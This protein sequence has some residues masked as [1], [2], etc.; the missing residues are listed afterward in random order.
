[1]RFNLPSRR[2]SCWI[3][4]YLQL[5]IAGPLFAIVPPQ[6]GENAGQRVEASGAITPTNATQPS[7]ILMLENNTARIGIDTTK[8]GAI[9][10]LSWKD[11]PGNIVN[12]HDP[13]RLIQQSYYAGRRLVRLADGQSKN[14]SPWS[15]NPIQGGGVGAWAHTTTA[16]LENNVLYS[17]ST[18]KLWDMDDEEA[19]AVMRQWTQ[20]EPNMPNVIAITCE[21]SCHRKASDPWGPAVNSPQEVPACYFTRNFTEVNSYLGTGSWR[22]EL[23]PPGP[24]WGKAQPPLNAMALFES[25]GQGVAIFSPTA[26]EHWN[27]GPHA[28]GHSHDPLAGPCMHVAPV[29]RVKLGP[30]STL[31]YRYWIAVGNKQELAKRLDQLCEQYKGEVHTLAE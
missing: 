17:E 8:G 24:P 31:R 2:I 26:T 23:Q 4:F 6:H 15:W 19:A 22:N 1:M 21:I 28:G 27:F 13:G 16:R 30:T 25:N 10:W 9:T 3:A 12:I 18:P 5:A 7:G 11:Y 14:W 20:F 29:S